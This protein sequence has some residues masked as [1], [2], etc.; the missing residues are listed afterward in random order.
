MPNSSHRGFAH[1]VAETCQSLQRYVQRFV[2]SRA[3]AEDIVQEA[4]ARTYAQGA[5]V[6]Q[7][8]AFLYVTARN[9]AYNANRHERTAATD[10][11]GD[12]DSTGAYSDDGLSPEDGLIADE[13]ARLLQEAVQ[14]LPP[15]CRAAFTMK[16]FQEL[17]YKQIADALGISTKTV[18]KHISKGLRDTHA[19]MRR[20]YQMP[21]RARQADG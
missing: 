14:R 6:A 12:I 11:V 15:Q 1:F 21:D 19:Y 4:Y 9:L 20:R 13:E 8:R 3:A 18:E 10:L 17:S 16:V 5:R 2:R 7:P